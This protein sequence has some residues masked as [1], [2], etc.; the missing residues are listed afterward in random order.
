MVGDQL[1]GVIVV[2]RKVLIK[3]G[4]RISGW[5]E[6][7]GR[8]RLL[9]SGG[10]AS[11]TPCSKLSARYNRLAAAMRY[12]CASKEHHGPRAT[13]QTCDRRLAVTRSPAG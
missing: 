12:Y 8:L 1:L 9:D 2:S 4:T 6:A 7:L 13:H 10:Q 3:H 11:T 5:A